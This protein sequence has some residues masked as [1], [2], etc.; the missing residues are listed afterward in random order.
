MDVAGEPLLV[1][2]TL[3]QIVQLAP[4]LVCE[5]GEQRALMLAGDFAESGEHFAA[6]RG[7][8]EG[9]AAPVILIAAA[10]DQAPAVQRIEQGNE[11]ARHH[12][13]TRG[14]GLLRDTGRCAEDA[15]D[16]GVRWRQSEGEQTLGEAR[17]GVTADLS[18]KESGIAAGFGGPGRTA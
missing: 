1:R 14:Q 6:R 12:L 10:L 2:Y 11:S 3:E 7:E 13:Q 16:A 5:R 8:V 18:E 4:L 17:S 15:Q 9:V